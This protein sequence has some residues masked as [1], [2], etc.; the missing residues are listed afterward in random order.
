MVGFSKGL[1]FIQISSNV[2]TKMFKIRASRELF[3]AADEMERLRANIQAFLSSVAED[4]AKLQVLSAFEGLYLALGVDFVNLERQYM[5][6][7]ELTD[8]LRPHRLPKN[9]TG[10]L[11]SFPGNEVHRGNI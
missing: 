11:I 3:G 4:E 2:E 1:Y 7:D 5:S 6:L 9:V 8:L 10:Y